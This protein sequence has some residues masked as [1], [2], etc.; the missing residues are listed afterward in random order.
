MTFFIRSNLLVSLAAVSFYLT[1]HWLLNRHLNNVFPASTTALFSATFIIYSLPKIP[2]TFS[3]PKENILFVIV[4]FANILILF[5]ASL[6]I[7]IRQTI[8][9]LHLGVIS[10]LYNFPFKISRIPYIPAR[11]IPFLKIIMI[12]YVWAS[13]GSVYCGFESPIITNA[14][15]VSVFMVQF[16]FIITITLPFDIR[17]H[18]IDKNS[19]IKTIPGLV[20]IEKTRYIGYVLA[21]V[22]ALFAGVTLSSLYAFITPGIVIILLTKNSGEHRNEFYYTGLIDGFIIV[23]FLLML[24]LY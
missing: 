2:G 22:Y 17:D 8:Y 3:F 13:I 16:L 20:G 1:G 19:G 18:I 6:N 9:L 24:V 23:N 4:L 5:V 7:P 11:T 12:A 21:F 10:F 15:V 14:K